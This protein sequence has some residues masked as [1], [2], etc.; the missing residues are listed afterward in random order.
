MSIHDARAG[1][2]YVDKDGKLWRVLWTC[3]EPSLGMVE[4]E[5]R[6]DSLPPKRTIEGG[7]SGRIW[8]GLRKILCADNSLP[9]AE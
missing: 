5:N 1:D 7:V 8:D 9:R 2:L 6:N 3:E 4:V